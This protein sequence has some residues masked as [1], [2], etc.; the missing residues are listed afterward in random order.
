[1]RYESDHKTKTR[2]RI[3]KNASR[4]IRAR[5]LSGSG[6]AGVMK[7]SGLTVGGFYKHFRS[8]DDLVI[9]AL[10][11]GLEEVRERYM[12][13]AS[14]APPGQEWK[15]IVRHYLSVEHCDHPEAGC[16]MAAL[17]SEISRATPA[18]KLRISN[19]IKEHAGHMAPI[20]PGRNAAEKEH[21]LICI[22][23]AMNGA[24]GMARMSAE[25]E[26]RKAILD[27]VRD[28]LLSSF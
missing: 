25:P 7:A 6:V 16:P 2:R 23:A 4:Q 28:H 22:V 26:R 18:M 15:E 11:Q 17:S 3:L 20:M 13:F 14:D 19:L 27:T 9:E 10:A 24:I 5:G 12:R 8:K 21:N 1:M